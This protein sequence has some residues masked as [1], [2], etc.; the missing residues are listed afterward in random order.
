M[1]LPAIQSPQTGPTERPVVHLTGATTGIGLATLR[2]LLTS[3]RYRIVATARPSSLKRFVDLGIKESE[4]L[5]TR[6]LDVTHPT[7]ADELFE[8]I[9]AEWDGVEVLINNAGISY[10]A[11]LE[12][13]HTRDERR[14]FDANYFGPMNLIRHALPYMRTRRFGRIINVSS[15]GGMMA[16]P[17]MSVYSASKFALEGAS[18]GL[19]YEL[20][21]WN[22][23]VVLVQPGFVRSD[24]FEN[25]KTTIESRRSWTC[26]AGAYHAH[27]DYMSRFIS[28]MMRHAWATPESIAKKILRAVDA[29]DPP[30]RIAGGMD[31]QWFSGLRRILPRRLYHWVLYQSLPGLRKWGS[32]SQSLNDPAPPQPS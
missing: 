16:M 22:I 19:W 18:E 30:L 26:P 13:M 5:K 2:L 6:P 25:V 1:N 11:V 28:K 17:T 7:M 32:E 20:R 23:R 8:E 27:Y 4:F 21:P 14:Q 9:E 15:V 24:G 10:R 12:H 29:T 31:A 3:A